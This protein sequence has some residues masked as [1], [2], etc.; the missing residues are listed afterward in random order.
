MMHPRRE[1]CL[2]TAFH[3]S[4]HVE[5]IIYSFRALS[6]DLIMLWSSFPWEVPPTPKSCSCAM[7]LPLLP[8]PPSIYSSQDYKLPPETKPFRFWVDSS[9]VKREVEW[10]PSSN[11]VPGDF[12]Y[13]M[14]A[15]FEV[16]ELD[17]FMRGYVRVVIGVTSLGSSPTGS[18][19]VWGSIFVVAPLL[20][21]SRQ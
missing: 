5:L 7:T 10:R 16:K 13:G 11:G 14:H 12:I 19:S 3:H 15:T 18:G 4:L 9:E 17:S 20:S 8:W 6:F 21:Y 1:W 2:R